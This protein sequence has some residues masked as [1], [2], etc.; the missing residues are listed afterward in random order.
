MSVALV[1]RLF[2]VEEY[3]KM[4]AAGILKECDQV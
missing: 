1:K 3:Y 4:M 2:T